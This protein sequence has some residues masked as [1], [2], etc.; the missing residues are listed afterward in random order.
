M[1]GFQL[2]FFTQQDRK[3]QG[4]TSATSLELAPRQTIWVAAVC[5]SACAA[6][7]IPSTKDRAIARR[8][9][10][11]IADESWS[12]ACRIVAPR[13]TVRR[14]LCGRAR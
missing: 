14:E 7:E 11:D 5:R 2:T 8:T 12:C 3:H 6:D 13:N 10:F 4:N 9:I 1:R